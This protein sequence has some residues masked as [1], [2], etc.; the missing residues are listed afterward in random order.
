MSTCIR[1][2]PFKV[3]TCKVEKLKHYSGGATEFCRIFDVPNKPLVMYNYSCGP[4]LLF[5]P[6]IIRK[7]LDSWVFN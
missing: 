3:I 4:G 5:W 2:L 7:G 1:D 6:L